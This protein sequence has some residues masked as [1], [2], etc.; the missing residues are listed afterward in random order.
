[1]VAMVRDRVDPWLIFRFF[2]GFK[3][4]GSTISRQPDNGLVLMVF[5]LFPREIDFEVHFPCNA[6]IFFG[7]LHLCPSLNFTISDKA[8]PRNCKFSIDLQNSYSS[9]NSTVPQS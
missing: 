3:G 8:T 6:D 2:G 5:H 1:M 7:G 9:I 4:S